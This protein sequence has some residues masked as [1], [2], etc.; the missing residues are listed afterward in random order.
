MLPGTAI[1]E[2]LLTLVLQMSLKAHF[3]PLDFYLNAKPHRQMCLKWQD[4]WAGPL[5]CT[6][7]QQGDP[8]WFSMDD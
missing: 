5:M 4:P 3:H 1:M 8:P 7:C 2:F 6:G